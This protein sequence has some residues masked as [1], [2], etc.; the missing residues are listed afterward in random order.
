[1]LYKD[2][3]TKI[4]FS[5]EWCGETPSGPGSSI[6][7][8]ENLRAQLPII[9]K[10]YNIKTIFD[11]P[12]GDLNW[13]KLI[14]AQNSEINYIGADIVEE[15]VKRNT[16]QYSKNNINFVELDIIKDPLPQADLMICRDCLFHLSVSDVQKFIKNFI[17]S[18]ISY[19]LTTC[20]FD[21]DVI[22]ADISPGSFTFLNLMEPPYNFS[23][24][25]LYTIDDWIEP[26][27]KRRMHLWGRDQIQSSLDS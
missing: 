7:Y 18:N 4:Y 27:P 12:C 19:L 1:M 20:H 16:E 8:T 17:K 25:P 5:N 13:M 15:I 3:F 26:W 24:L 6:Q 2:I 10:K 9:F 23:K 21:V 22:N 11:A 14:L